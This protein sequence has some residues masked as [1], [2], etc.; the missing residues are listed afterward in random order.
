MKEY[1]E[2]TSIMRINQIFSFENFLSMYVQIE[3]LTKENKQ[4]IERQMITE[5]IQSEMES[6]IQLLKS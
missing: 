3:K 4:M 2:M 5:K 1:K 6:E